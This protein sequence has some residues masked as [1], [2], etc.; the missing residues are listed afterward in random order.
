LCAR[1]EAEYSAAG[2]SAPE[3]APQLEDDAALS[4]DPLLS[5]G[6]LFSVELDEVPLPLPGG[7]LE[8]LE[9]LDF[10]AVSDLALP[11]RA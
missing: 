11:E 8:P 4:D 5:D 10:S 7:S 1:D 9:A 3:L 6:P 2:A